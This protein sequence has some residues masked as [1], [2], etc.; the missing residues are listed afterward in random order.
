MKIQWSALLHRATDQSLTTLTL[1]VLN[2]FTDIGT[3]LG[4][5]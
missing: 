4:Q 1:P 5:I 3:R 2:G